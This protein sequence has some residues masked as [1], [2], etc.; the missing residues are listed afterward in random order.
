MSDET[1]WL[2]GVCV[3]GSGHVKGAKACEDAHFLASSD[4]GSFVLVAC[5]GAGSKRLSRFG[6]AAV[7]PAVGQLL[8]T[9]AEQVMSRK[10]RP[11]V[12]VDVALSAIESLRG[13]HGGE[14][15]DFACT[16][17]AALVHGGHLMTCHVGDGAIFALEGE[18]PRCISPPDRD[19]G[20]GPYTTFVTC[21]TAKPRMWSYPVPD[22]LTGLLC[23][24]DGAQP[25]LMNTVTGACSGLVARVL[26]RFDLGDSRFER[27]AL[28]ERVVEVELQPRT[29]DDITLVGARRAFIAGV[30]G[31]PECKRPTVEHRMHRTGKAFFGLCK[32][33]G[34]Q[35]FLHDENV[36]ETRKRYERMARGVGMR[37]PSLNLPRVG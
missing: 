28:L 37:A 31:C 11:E 35:V 3:Q 30:Y 33:C 4:E 5:D 9:H 16:L 21:K 23:V 29:E 14:V 19:P 32:S 25:A 6:A 1:W 13:L 15:G 12:V 24:T 10:L 17:V 2:A 27:E 36:Q 34:H 26:N 7:A 8:L 22:H 20:G 18:H